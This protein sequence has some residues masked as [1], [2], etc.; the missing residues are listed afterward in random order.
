MKNTWA[1]KMTPKQRNKV[2]EQLGHL[3]QPA[4]DSALEE[5]AAA[6]EFISSDFAGSAGAISG[7][8]GGGS[9][10]LGVSFVSELSSD[11]KVFVVVFA[12]LIAAISYL[13][14]SKN[15]ANDAP[16]R[17]AIVVC[18]LRSSVPAVPAVESRRSGT[19]SGIVAGA[20]A[21]V[22]IALAYLAFTKRNAR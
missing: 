5:Y 22:A 8:F 17:A 21:G 18:Q 11:F 7:I 4:I 14:M 19:G 20:S 9:I 13:A 6:N 1:D 16:R 15:S 2:N 12:I 3:E 10:V